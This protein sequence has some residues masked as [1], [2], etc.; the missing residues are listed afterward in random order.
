MASIAELDETVRTASV[1]NSYDIVLSNIPE[2]VKEFREQGHQAEYIKHAFEPRLLSKI[3]PNFPKTI[4]VSF[5]GSIFKGQSYHLE[6][7]KLIKK[8]VQK[9][10]LQIWSDLSSS[11]PNKIKQLPFH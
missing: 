10:N 2:F 4:D 1:F 8:L 9:T 7:E 3:N 5:V 6:R 11:S